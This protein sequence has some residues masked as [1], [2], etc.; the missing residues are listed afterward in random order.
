MEEG[1]KD[2]NYQWWE[3]LQQKILQGM[4]GLYELTA[5]VNTYRRPAQYQAIQEF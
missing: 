2:C 3:P 1:Q 4:I 5:V